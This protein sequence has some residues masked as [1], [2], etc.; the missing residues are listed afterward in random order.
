MRPITTLVCLLLAA[1][2]QAQCTVSYFSLAG[3]PMRWADGYTDAQ[4]D[5]WAAL[6][7]ADGTG[8]A[9]AAR[10]DASGQ[11]VWSYR[12]AALSPFVK[13]YPTQA[14]ATAS[15]GMLI[16]GHR[17]SPS[18]ENYF[19]MEVDAQGELLWSSIYM[20]PYSMHEGYGGNPMVSA[21]LDGGYQM[22]V[23]VGS[24]LVTA[25]LNATGQQV[26]CKHFNDNSGHTG[27]LSG[28]AITPGG[29]MIFAT[30]PMN[31]D[32]F[33]ADTTTTLVWKTDTNGDVLWVRKLSGI[34]FTC[35][36]VE[37]ATNG[38]ILLGGR[39]GTFS[40]DQLTALARLSAS[41]DLLWANSYDHPL[42]VGDIVEAGNGDLLASLKV[43]NVYFWSGADL[44]DSTAVIQV[45]SDGSA[46]SELVV[47]FG[48]TSFV[49]STW[50][51]VMDRIDLARGVD[52]SLSMAVNKNVYGGADSVQWIHDPGGMDLSCASQ[53]LM[54]TASPIPNALNELITFTSVDDSIRIWGLAVTG[55]DQTQTDVAVQFS[56]N[57]PPR[58]G[59]SHTV[60]GMALNMGGVSTGPLTATMTFD[61]M[62]T[63]VSADPSPTS[64]VGN[65]L[66]WTGQPALT[67]YI[68][69]WWMNATFSVPND[70][71]LLGQVV[72]TTLS[73]TQDTAEV[74]L[75]NN[76]ASIIQTVV[77]SY[78]PN[79]KLVQPAGLYHIL[80]DD[81]L[82]YTIRFQNT[83][84]YPAETVVIRDTLPLYVDIL[85]LRPGPA[86]HPY[87]YTVTGSG[88]LVF[89]FA[90]IN[91]PDSGSNEQASH[92][93]VSFSIQPI[94]PLTLG[95][96]IT[97][98]ADIFFDFN[99][100]I[101]TPDATVVVTDQTGVRPSVTP[102]RLMVYP[103]PAK[104]T[105]TAVLPEG[106]TLAQAWALGLDGRR[107][108]L[109]LPTNRSGQVQLST[110]HLAAG[111][112]V[113][114]LRAQDGRR[115]AAR[116]VK[117]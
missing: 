15:G 19:G 72:E 51:T 113:L 98:V 40:S 8:D 68:G 88:H 18:H 91:L 37:L 104:N 30:S 34:E 102:A 92:G 114:T 43:N 58:P 56:Q 9:I 78:D 6:F 85:T 105:L 89:T 77:G 115:L 4:G 14:L 27:P 79:D 12:V 60:Y 71:A 20:E 73:V 81:E 2:V 53:S 87:T 5:T 42:L 39:I 70:T 74:D 28:Q 52:G 66:T 100:P 33:S 76:T 16:I 7:A 69:T 62:M 3:L 116:F 50:Y 13:L 75:D 11:L 90:N 84:T 38:D 94:L 46:S 36:L 65:T 93:M 47:P 103:V 54:G 83:G 111:A 57:A 63:F 35:T 44:I 10:F 80:N 82:H 106:F 96:E 95:Q 61:P 97:N 1:A 117:E 32:G 59:F 110:H 49:P 24:G 55:H 48:S 108:P 17:V 23:P 31:A 25:R 45:S 41:G 86:S 67:G 21:T 99:E 107:I 64:V 101:R 112:Y 26:W 109:L 22:T 29:E